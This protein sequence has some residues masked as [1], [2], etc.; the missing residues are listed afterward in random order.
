MFTFTGILIKEEQGYS[1]LCPE[2]D[3]ASTGDIPEEAKTMLLEAATLHLEGA[4]EDGLPY[5]RP[6]PSDAD[7]RQIAPETVAL[8]FRFKVDVAVRAYA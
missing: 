3:V 5:A 1:A 7:P 6:V 4:F 2:L 8:V